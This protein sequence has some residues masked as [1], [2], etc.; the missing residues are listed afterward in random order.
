[1]AQVDSGVEQE[2]IDQLASSCKMAAKNISCMLRER[3]SLPEPAANPGQPTVTLPVLDEI[4]DTLRDCRDELSETV[5]FLT[6]H[7]FP[8]IK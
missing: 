6:M 5:R 1:M 2:T 4:V 3:F 8:K 7:V